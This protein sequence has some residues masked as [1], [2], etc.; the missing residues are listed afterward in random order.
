VLK[1][2]SLHKT[3]ISGR[4][5]LEDSEALIEAIEISFNMK[6]QQLGSNKILLTKKI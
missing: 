4:F 1:D 6:S 2:P 5:N 3:K